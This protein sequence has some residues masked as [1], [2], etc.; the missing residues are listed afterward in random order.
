[1]RGGDGPIRGPGA[2]R[3]SGAFFERAEAAHGAPAQRKSSTDMPPARGGRA[4]ARQ[5]FA[6][7]RGLLLDE[8]VEEAVDDVLSS[9]LRCRRQAGQRL[10]GHRLHQLCALG[11]V[12]LASAWSIR[13][14]SR[15]TLAS[16]APRLQRRGGFRTI[17]G[18]AGKSDRRG[19]RIMGNR[20]PP[21]GRSAGGTGAMPKSICKTRSSWSPARRAASGGPPR[22]P[23]PPRERASRWAPAAPTGWRRSCLSYARRAPARCSPMPWTC[24]R[25]RRSRPSSR[26]PCRRSGALI[27]S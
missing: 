23:S 16:G 13:F 7:Q 21:P 5:D 20:P 19:W 26:R 9:A 4:D 12:Q 14:S 22:S 10:V 25:S 3:R 27:S 6:H 8:P 15:A 2:H 11:R 18:R 24:A 17:T 1:M